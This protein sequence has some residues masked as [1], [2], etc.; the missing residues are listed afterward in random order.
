MKRPVR[1][2]PGL[3]ASTGVVCMVLIGAGCQQTQTTQTSAG[4]VPAPE[5]WQDLMAKEKTD[6][7]DQAVALYVDAMMLIELNNHAEAIRMLQMATEL[8]PEFAL[9]FSLQGDLYQQTHEYEK[10]AQAYEKA[11]ELDP[12]SFK[13]FFNLGKVYQALK[14]FARAVKAYVSACTLNPKHYEAHYNAAQCFYLIQDYSQSMDYAQKAKTIDP[15]RAEP[16]ILLGDLYEVQKDHTQAI[17]AYR[18]ALELEGNKPEIM[19]S[20]PRL[21]AFRPVQRR[22]GTSVGSC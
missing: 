20:G 16:E 11:T 12:W 15:Q 21:S 5:S 7:R 17:N 18:R 1:F 10:S 4:P 22:Q 3:L 9:A 8:D 2:Y 13:D 19:L 14:E 6:Q